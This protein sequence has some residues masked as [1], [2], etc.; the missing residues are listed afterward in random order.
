MGLDSFPRLPR[1]NHAW[2]EHEVPPPH[3]LG[4]ATLVMELIP[5]VVALVRHGLTFETCGSQAL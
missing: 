1:L 4:P 3:H 5:I 2:L